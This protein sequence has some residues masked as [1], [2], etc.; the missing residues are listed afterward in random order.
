MSN[1]SDK[2]AEEW[3]EDTDLIPMTAS[4]NLGDFQS[5]VSNALWENDEVISLEVRAVRFEDESGFVVDMIV[6]VET[7]MT[8]AHWRRSGSSVEIQLDVRSAD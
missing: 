3:D 6:G 2:S 1:I 5:L 8:S 4:L 7:G